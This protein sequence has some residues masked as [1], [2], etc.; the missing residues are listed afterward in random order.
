MIAIIVYLFVGLISGFITYWISYRIAKAE[1]I[2]KADKS[3]YKTHPTHAEVKEEVV[4]DDMIPIFLSVVAWPIAL[5]IVYPFIGVVVG[6][7][8]LFNWIIDKVEGGKYSDTST[9]G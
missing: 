2:E 4:K 3:R 5:F 1:L 9:K 7:C 6:S 8:A